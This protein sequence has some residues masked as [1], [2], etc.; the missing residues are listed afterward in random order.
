VPVPAGRASLWL[1]PLAL[2]TSTPKSRGPSS[3]FVRGSEFQYPL[4][5]NSHFEK[6][7]NTIE[8]AVREAARRHSDLVIFP[9][10]LTMDLWQLNPGKTDREI[11]FDVARQ[12]TEP[13][14]H[15]V[16]E[17]SR[18][19]QI[20]I[21][22]GSSPRV[23]NNEIYNTAMIAFPDGRQIFHDK[24]FLTEW[25]KDQGWKTGDSLTVF[26]APWGKTVILTCFD[27]E[28]P[29]TTQA[30]AAAAPEWILIPSM[31]ETEAGLKR[32][33]WSAQARAVEHHAFVVV[34][35]TV[36]RYPGWEQVGQAA[37]LEPLEKCGRHHQ[38]GSMKFFPF[39]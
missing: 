29:L 24:V 39:L 20:A 27:S 21:L 15:F 9:E 28:F 36:G 11:S 13:Y 23:R 14:F 1:A 33:R 3:G 10:L 38:H 12:Y 16:T 5:P 17:L 7:K 2:D 18:R 26:D 6:L 37:L 19:H 8:S 32:V 25:E 4:E 22:A 35:G 30:L 31:T 34:T